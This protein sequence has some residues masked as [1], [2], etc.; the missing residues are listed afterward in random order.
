VEFGRKGL[1]EQQYQPAEEG[2]MGQGR[3]LEHSPARK[4]EHR[5]KS[6]L[7]LS[8]LSAELALKEKY[9]S[10]GGGFFGQFN[11]ESPLTDRPPFKVD[12]SVQFI[13]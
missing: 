8:A 11:P 1:A 5:Q 6:F 12:Y 13:K 4:A 9:N 10:S 2:G 7:R 3:P